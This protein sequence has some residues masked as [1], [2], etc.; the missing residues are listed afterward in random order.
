M[1]PGEAVCLDPLKPNTVKRCER[2]GDPNIM[3]IISTKPAFVGD[4]YRGSESN[5]RSDATTAIVG[6]IGQLPAKAVTQSGQ[7]IAIGD[8]LA[9][10]AKPGFVRKAMAGE[11]TVGVALTSLASGEGMVDVLIT[12]RNQSDLVEKIENEVTQSIADMHIE[13][14][15]RQMVQNTMNGANIPGAVAAAVQEQVAAL[16]MTA[17]INSVLD[18]RLADGSLSLLSKGSLPAD[19]LAVVKGDG[20]QPI[21]DAVAARLGVVRTGSASLA[22]HRDLTIDGALVVGKNLTVDVTIHA[23]AISGP[24]KLV[25]DFSVEPAFRLGNILFTGGIVR[26]GELGTPGALEVVGI[27]NLLDV[28]WPTQTSG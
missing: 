13:D 11:S 24:L 18:Q 5:R 16:N 17:Q 22:L 15:V 14:D 7:A 10:A 6:L 9:A 28:C 26:I 23:A 2:S 1:Q 8:A 21:A 19:I 20:G 27:M 4:K 3:G 25:G 12:R